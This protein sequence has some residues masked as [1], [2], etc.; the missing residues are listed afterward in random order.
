MARDLRKSGHIDLLH[1]LSVASGISG[2]EAQVLS[3][4][5]KVVSD[6]GGIWQL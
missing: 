2:S 4:L 3:V 1:L 5:Y 6:N